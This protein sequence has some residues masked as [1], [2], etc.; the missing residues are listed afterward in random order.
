MKWSK[1]TIISLVIVLLF[2]GSIFGVAIRS[3]NGGVSKDDTPTDV[4]NIVNP[5][6]N[7]PMETYYAQMDM[8]ILDIYPQLILQSYTTEFDQ[9][10]IDL[11]L[12][13]IPG[14]KTTNLSFNKSDDQNIILVG[15]IVIDPKNKEDIIN[16]I[17]D[18]NFLKEKNI[19]QSALFSLPSKIINLKSV[20]S[21]KERQYEFTEAKTDGLVFT[22]TQK[23]DAVEAELR[24]YFQGDT[25]RVFF[26]SELKNLSAAPQILSTE[27]TLPVIQFIGEIIINCETSVLTT[28]DENKLKIDLNQPTLR[29]NT[30]PVGFLSFNITD[31]TKNNDINNY[32][33]TTKNNYETAISNYIIDG[34]IGQIKFT[35][36]LTPEKYSEITTTLNG[37]DIDTNYI[38]IPKEEVYL[39]IDED[40]INVPIITSK[41]NKLNIQITDMYK[42]ADVNLKTVIANEITYTYESGKVSSWVKYPTDA[43]KVDY[44]FSIDAYHIRDKIV[45]ATLIEK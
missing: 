11:Q 2:V 31:T 19:Y 29:V 30:I 42:A 45:Q 22:T 25:P 28:I 39:T 16:S 12:K 44:D 41:L 10:V 24:I 4:N 13:K 32:L 20:D 33:D 7:L 8:N 34:N 37:F 43:N 6:A 27:I 14:V 40:E 9:S 26:T 5:D 15:K 3:N 21:N 18:L 17:N 1:E 23:G 35:E 38:T 36:K